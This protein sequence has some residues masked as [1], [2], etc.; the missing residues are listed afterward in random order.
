MKVLGFCVTFSSIPLAV[1]LYR[2]LKFGQFMHFVPYALILGGTAI[3]VAADP[4]RYDSF[5]LASLA[6][7]GTAVPHADL[8]LDMRKQSK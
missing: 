2:T 8:Y 6:L 7:L 3:A 5:V 4:G 1:F